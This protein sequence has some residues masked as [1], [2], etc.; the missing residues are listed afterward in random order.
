MCSCTSPSLFYY[1]YS[2]YP[3][4]QSIYMY[5]SILGP[6][7]CISQSSVYMCLCLSVFP[8][9]GC[10]SLYFSIFVLLCMYCL[11]FYLC[12]CIYF[13]ILGL[14]ISVS[15]FSIYMYLYL[16]EFPRLAC[17]SLCFQSSFFY[18]YISHSSIHVSVFCNLQYIYVSICLNFPAFILLHLYFQPFDSCVCISQSSFYLWKSHNIV[19]TCLNIQILIL[20]CLY[21]IFFNICGCVPKFSAYMFMYFPICSLYVSSFASFMYMTH[22]LFSLLSLYIF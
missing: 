5:C 16:P 21:F 4:L 15:S 20:L 2:V 1:A 18:A 12:V 6:Q 3:I 19:F 14:Q 17:M 9:L 11:L 10:M 7:V 13:S 22:I 8:S